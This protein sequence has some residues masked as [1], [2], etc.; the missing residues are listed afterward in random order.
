MMLGVPTGLGDVEHG[1]Q[2]HFIDTLSKKVG[3]MYVYSLLHSKG[4]SM[5]NR[6]SVSVFVR[7]EHS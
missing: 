5:W 3:L 1:H 2:E 6:I 7:L 4:H